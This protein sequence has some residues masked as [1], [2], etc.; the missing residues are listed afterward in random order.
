MDYAIF[1][2]SNG[3]KSNIKHLKLERNFLK[4]KHD[5]QRINGMSR[6]ILEPSKL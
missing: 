2:F 6:S 1:C 3:E 4:T 5:E